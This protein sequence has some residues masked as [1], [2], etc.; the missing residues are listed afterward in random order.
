MQPQM[1]SPIINYSNQEVCKGLAQQI[2]M[3][4]GQGELGRGWCHIFGVEMGQWSHLRAV[5]PGE[6]VERM[7]L[8]NQSPAGVFGAKPEM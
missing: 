5:L 1:K 7:A 8:M 2:P 3:E 6:P 4:R